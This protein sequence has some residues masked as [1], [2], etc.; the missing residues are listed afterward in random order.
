M[1][2]LTTTVPTM[3][4]VGDT[5]PNL[6]GYYVENVC[7]MREP[8]AFNQ[9]TWGAYHGPQGGG[10][11]SMPSHVA[12][13]ANGLTI[14]AYRDPDAGGF[15]GAAGGGCMF[16]WPIQDT[17][18]G[19][20]VCA[21][22]SSGPG[23]IKAV[24]LRWP[25]DNQWAEGEDDF[26]EGPASGAKFYLHDVGVTPANS[27][28][29]GGVPNNLGDGSAHVSSLRYNPDSGFALLSDGTVYHTYD[30]LAQ[31]P[32]KPGQL[33]IQLQ[34]TATTDATVTL[35]VY[36]VAFWGYSKSVP[37]APQTPPEASSALTLTFTPPLP[38]GTTVALSGLPQ[39]T[40]T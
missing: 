27:A 37:V 39:A 31:V 20:D 9:Y 25:T 24:F 32:S 30:N 33:A 22:M 18:G 2:Q 35:Q 10:G 5:D 36:W 13:D 7:D 21:A 8:G 28:D 23:T 16:T 4:K 38:A 19:I 14:V 12:Q 34:D 3:P 6:P 17:G 15:K 26:R 1:T 40:V 29:Q 11:Y